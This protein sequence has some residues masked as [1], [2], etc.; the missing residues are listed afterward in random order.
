MRDEPRNRTGAL[1]RA[2]TAACGRS[3]SSPVA[4]TPRRSRAQHSMA[5]RSSPRTRSGT[6]SSLSQPNP[7]GFTIVKRTNP[8]STWLFSAA[9]KR[10]PG[11]AFAGDLA[12]GSQ[13]AS[14]ISGS[15]SR[16][17]L[18]SGRL[19][20]RRR[21]SSHG[22]GRPTHRDG[23]APL[24]HPGHGLDAAYED[25]QP[26]LSTAYGVAR[27]SE[28]DALPAGPFPPARHRRHGHRR[29][30]APV[31]S[32]ARRSTS[33]HGCLWRLE[34]A[35]PVHAFQEIHRGRPRFRA[36]PTTSGRL[37]IAPGTGS[38]SMATSCIPI[39][40]PVTSGITTGVVM[41][42]TTRNWARRFGSGKLPAQRPRRPVP[43]RRGARTQHQRDQLS[44]TSAR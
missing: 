27:T 25:V 7:D 1:R 29:Q 8:K 3:R 17:G 21:R 28:T 9:G 13:S 22:S 19:E 38:G 6:I 30:P 37:T 10:A 4:A 31:S 16:P 34:P 5:T 44:T 39:L 12:G 36:L 32:R 14:R 26:G 24:R 20:A 40:R 15:R 43:A 23:H 35:G 33:T 41:P 42:G 2:P 11:L 18:R